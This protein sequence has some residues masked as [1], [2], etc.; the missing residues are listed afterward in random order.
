MAM[1]APLLRFEGFTLELA[2]ASGWVRVLDGIDLAVGEGEALALV[3]ESGSGKTLC[4]QSVTRLMPSGVA[5]CTAG[6]VRLAG[7]DV[8]QSPE[9]ALRPLRGG[10]VGHVFQEPAA[11][12]NP[13]LR[14]GDQVLEALRLHRPA[15]A[16]RAEVVRWLARVGIPAPEERARQF[17]HELSG[18]LQQRVML[19]IALAPRPRL[20]VADE[21]TTALDVTVQAQVLDLLA[22]LRRELGMAI[23]LVTH[24]LGVV[25]GLADRV[26]VLYAGQVVEHGPA[27]D[28]LARPLHPYTRALVESVPRLGRSAPSLGSLP[29][30]VPTPGAWPDGCRFHPRCPQAQPT[31]AGEQPPWLDL[32]GGRG[33]RCPFAGQEVRG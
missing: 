22:S 3:G 13:V 21:P 18:G 9:R 32:A 27:R 2:T 19:A 16:S 14:V 17:P 11:A 30:S 15:E 31:C 25:E 29:G 28:V 33:V 12:L 8:F 20:L 6:S 1:G 26:A 7:V 24:N 23:L 10:V 5:R 4:A